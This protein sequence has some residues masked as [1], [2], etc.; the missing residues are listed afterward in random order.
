MPSLSF[1]ERLHAAIAAR[2]P[3]CVGIDPHPFLLTG[4]PT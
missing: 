3:L 2:G 1:G 4:T